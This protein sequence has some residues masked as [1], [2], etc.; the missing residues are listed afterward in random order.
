[1]R[2]GLMFYDLVASAIASLTERSMMVE[3]KSDWSLEIS[4][5]PI[6]REMWNPQPRGS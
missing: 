5:T 6:S 1:M 3:Y 2:L 4:V